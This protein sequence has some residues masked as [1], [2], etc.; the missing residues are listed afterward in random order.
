[1][2]QTSIDH[3]LAYAQYKIKKI[4]TFQTHRKTLQFGKAH[5]RSRF[6]GEKKE[7]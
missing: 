1:M 4:E 2:D 5:T 3:Q 7:G 6:R